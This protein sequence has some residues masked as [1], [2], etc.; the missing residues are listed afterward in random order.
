MTPRDRVDDSIR[1]HLAGRAVANLHPRVGEG[2]DLQAIDA[3]IGLDRA[4]DRHVQ[5]RDNACQNRAVDL[6]GFHGD[7]GKKSQQ[8]DSEFV[9]GVQDR[10]QT[11]MADQLFSVKHP[12]HRRGIPR[13][14]N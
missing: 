13:V 5:R 2:V 9:R 6:R 11:P 1:P 8:I 4:A 10:G 12:H 3:E 7:R 14:H